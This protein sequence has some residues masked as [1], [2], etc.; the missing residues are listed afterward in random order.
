[1]FRAANAYQCIR[2]D[3]ALSKSTRDTEMFTF[4][5]EQALATPLL[6]NNV[7]F[8][9]RQLWTY[10]LGIHDC[11][12]EKGC[13]HMW[14]EGI[15]SQGS[16]EIGSCLLHHLRKMQSQATKLILYSDSCGGQNRNINLVC[17]WMHIVSSPEYSI[18]QIDQKFMVSGHSYL[19]NDHD[20]A[21][22]ETAKRRAGRVYAPEEWYQLVRDC[23]RANAFHVEEIELDNFVSLISLTKNI[24]NRKVTVKK[25]KVDWF[26][27][28]WIQ[29][30]KD[31][32]FAFKYRCS[33]NDFE[34]WKEVDV[35]RKRQGR[36]VDMGRVRL[37]P[38][39]TGP[40]AIKKAKMDDLLALLAYVPPA[41][42][43]FYQSLQS[44]ASS[45][46][47]EDT[48]NDSEC[49][50]ESSDEDSGSDDSD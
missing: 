24:V 13:M 32:P 11:K 8:Y 49:D 45:G 16:H 9:K 27:I 6:T 34:Q 48:D 7:V 2:E 1:M 22:I 17:L 30:T 43:S 50:E 18:T 46:S 42:H 47:L 20:F 3:T 19:P 15:G 4:D 38:L 21:S 29:V 28:R 10:N 26:S 37:Q 25:Q 41:Y 44:T 40:R 36:S 23:R 12:T 39:F 14:H 33:L 5:L 31:K 35:K